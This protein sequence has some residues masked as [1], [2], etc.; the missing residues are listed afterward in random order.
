MRREWGILCESKRRD[1]EQ[2]AARAAACPAPAR[3]DG[4]WAPVACHAPGPTCAPHAGQR[5][6]ARSAGLAQPER[7]EGCPWRGGY[8]HTS[9]RIS[10]AGLSPE[11]DAGTTKAVEGLF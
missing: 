4:A 8:T 6:A 7:G 9:P 10:C 3:P 11:G 1:S 5:R 2:H